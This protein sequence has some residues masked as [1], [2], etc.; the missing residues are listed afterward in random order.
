MR[1]FICIVDSETFEY[2][3]QKIVTLLITYT[4]PKKRISKEHIVSEIAGSVVVIS[5]TYTLYGQVW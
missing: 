4:N 3:V 2:V 5:L 1:Y